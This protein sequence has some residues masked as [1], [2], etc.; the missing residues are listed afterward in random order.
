MD[1]GFWSK[2]HHQ[3]ELIEFTYLGIYSCGN[4]EN[5]HFSHIFPIFD[6]N[7]RP[8]MYSVDWLWVFCI[9]A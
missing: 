4:P 9:S 5:I 3:R 7:Y 1:G 8:L 6:C 2:I